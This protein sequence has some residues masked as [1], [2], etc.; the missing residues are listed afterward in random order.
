M[1]IDISLTKEIVNQSLPVHYRHATFKQR[2]IPYAT[3]VVLLIVGIFNTITQP[4]NIIGIERYLYLIVFTVL[5]VAYTFWFDYKRKS[6]GKAM[7]KMLGDRTDYE[8]EATDDGLTTRLTDATYDQKWTVYPKAIISKEVVLLYQQNK[9]FA[10]FHH[11]FFSND[12]F[13]RFKNLV[14]KHMHEVKED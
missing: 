2:A 5:G 8:V 13:D 6:A 7:I 1:I 10:I 3:G 4:D 14:R 11:S 12:D 9:S